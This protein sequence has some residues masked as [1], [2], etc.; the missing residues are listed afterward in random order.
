M[1]VFS[2]FDGISVGLETLLNAGVDVTEYH[3][4]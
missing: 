2:G 1:I 4:S 3:S